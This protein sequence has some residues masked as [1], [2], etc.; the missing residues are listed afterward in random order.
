[1]LHGVQNQIKVRKI[2]TITGTMCSEL[3]EVIRAELYMQIQP[4]VQFKHSHLSTFLFIDP[5]HSSHTTHMYLAAYS[6][7]IK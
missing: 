5:I 1:M 4:R 2:N 7:S 3:V 6:S